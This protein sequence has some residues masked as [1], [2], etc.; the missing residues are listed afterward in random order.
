VKEPYTASHEIAYCMG[1][2]VGE[3]SFTGDKLQPAL[4][5]RLHGSDPEPLLDL[6]RVFVA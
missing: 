6:Q 5:V 3:G 2:I 1:L 4:Q